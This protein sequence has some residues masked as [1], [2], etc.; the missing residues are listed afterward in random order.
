MV[1]HKGSS[2][3]YL[4]LSIRWKTGKHFFKS[5]W[6]KIS[7]HVFVLIVLGTITSICLYRSLA[8]VSDAIRVL[9]SLKNFSGRAH[10]E[11]KNIIFSHNK[12]KD[13]GQSS[14]GR[15]STGGGT[16]NNKYLGSD[17]ENRSSHIELGTECSASTK[18]LFPKKEKLTKEV[19]IS[20]VGQ[21][22]KVVSSELK[23]RRLQMLKRKI[24]LLAQ[25]FC[26][27]QIGF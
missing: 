15:F 7:R 18:L 22:K 19:S 20:A 25:D 23:V 8:T 12:E 13:S 24:L 26:T 2:S 17:T 6:T 11:R 5:L 10:E 4:T 16:E 21:N 9:C 3:F 27:T 14:A 1:L